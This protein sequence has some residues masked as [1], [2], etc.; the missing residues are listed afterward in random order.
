[1]VSGWKFPENLCFL[2]STFSD[3]LSRPELNP[4]LCSSSN[5]KVYKVFAQ[6]F[7]QEEILSY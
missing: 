4:I 2:K 1:V 6:C 7:L 3:F 5:P